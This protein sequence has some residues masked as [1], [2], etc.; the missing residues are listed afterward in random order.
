MV[1][2]EQ[3]KTKKP[4]T[5]FSLTDSKQIIARLLEKIG[6]DDPASPSS[7]S[8]FLQLLKD[9]LEKARQSTEIDLLANR[10]GVRCAQNLSLTEDEIIRSILTF[11]VDY[12]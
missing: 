10:R 6:D 1:M 5:V 9:E 12:V 4:A 8:L 2:I 7:R 11:A 3:I